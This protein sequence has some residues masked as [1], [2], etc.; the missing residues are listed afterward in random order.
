MRPKD[1]EKWLP[2][3][4]VLGRFGETLAKPPFTGD[5]VICLGHGQAAS[6]GPDRLSTLNDDRKASRPHA[7]LGRLLAATGSR[8]SDEMWTQRMYAHIVFFY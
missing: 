1:P 7:G 2:E 5:Q 3:T 8:A 4:T 6:S